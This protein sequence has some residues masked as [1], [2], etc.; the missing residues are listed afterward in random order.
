MKINLP[1]CS[2]SVSTSAFG[3]SF[4]LSDRKNWLVSTPGWAPSQD[5]LCCGFKRMVMSSMAA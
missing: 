3:M 1:V 5:G 4:P 2:W